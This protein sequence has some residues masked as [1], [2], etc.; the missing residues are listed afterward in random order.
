MFD[1]LAGMAGGAVS[2]LSSLR[3]QLRHEI[4]AR[5][6]EIISRMDLVPRQDFEALEAM[7]LKMKAELDAQ[8]LSKPAKMQT[9][10]KK[11]AKSAQKKKTKRVKQ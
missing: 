9:T 10:P 4:R 6:D 8:K 2:L 1:D 11:S 7:V 3:T 5:I